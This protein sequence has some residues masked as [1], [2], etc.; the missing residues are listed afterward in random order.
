MHQPKLGDTLQVCFGVHECC[1]H[2]GLRWDEP[3]T[4]GRKLLS[5][6]AFAGWQFA[7]PCPEPSN[8]ERKPKFLSV[9]GRHPNL[10]DVY[11]TFGNLPQVHIIV[12]G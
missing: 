8:L 12:G 10:H 5:T 9:A 1:L 6:V 7:T 11:A 4:V 3:F 2:P